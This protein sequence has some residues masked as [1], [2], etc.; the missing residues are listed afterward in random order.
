MDGQAA[1]VQQLVQLDGE[2]AQIDGITM[3]SGQTW[4]LATVKQAGRW[5]VLTMKDG[6]L[7]SG[8]TGEAGG[9]PFRTRATALRQHDELVFHMGGTRVERADLVLDGIVFECKTVAGMV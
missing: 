2:V 3:P 1:E 6:T 7:I 5:H 4:V 8:P 9:G